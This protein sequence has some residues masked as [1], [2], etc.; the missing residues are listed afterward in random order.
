MDVRFLVFIMLTCSA[1]AAS[2]QVHSATGGRVQRITSTTQA[3][4]NPLS[5]SVTPFE[6]DQYRDG[7]YPPHWRKFCQDYESHYIQGEA[8]RVGRPSP[9]A[10]VVSL[11]ALGSVAAKSTGMAC[12]GGTSM[13]RLSNGWE[14]V[15]APD[16]G[17]Q[18]CKESR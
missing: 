10:S 7:N 6:C 1:V 16:G 11:P 13:R 15:S 5:K 2:A 14:Q 3:A 12:V 8:R 4:A 17:W 18:R 9:S